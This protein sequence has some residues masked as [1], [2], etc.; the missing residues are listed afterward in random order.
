MRHREVA[1]VLYS[2]KD[3]GVDTSRMTMYMNAV[4]A[5]C[6]DL[7]YFLG[8]YHAFGYASDF[9][10]IKLTDEGVKMCKKTIDLDMI[11]PRAKEQLEHLKVILNNYTYENGK[12]TLKRE[13]PAKTNVNSCSGS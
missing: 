2:L 5:Y 7:D 1:D 4:S 10:P 13:E 12:I 8:R 9:D 3:N 6:W 11:K